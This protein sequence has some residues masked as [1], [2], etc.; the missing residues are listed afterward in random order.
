MAE[1][2]IDWKSLMIGL[3]LGLV[4]ILI[5]AQDRNAPESLPG[6]Y[7]ITT[8]ASTWIINCDTGDVWQL[9]GEQGTNKFIWVYAGKPSAALPKTSFA[10]FSKQFSGQK[11]AGYIQGNN[12]LEQLFE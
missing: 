1:Q 7:Q 6:H 12:D 2:K 3:L 9:T 11:N 8:G 10:P 4:A 5:A